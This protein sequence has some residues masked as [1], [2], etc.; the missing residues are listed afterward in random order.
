[1][2][3]LRLMR[4]DIYYGYCIAMFQKTWPFKKSF[5]IHVL[6]VVESGIQRYWE[7]QVCKSCFKLHA[8][9][10]LSNAKAR[11]RAPNNLRSTL[12]S[13]S[14]LCILVD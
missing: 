6:H 2:H 11:A 4:D 14:L 5:D 8:Y 12:S 1:M 13:V 7:T 3:D 10:I 9:T